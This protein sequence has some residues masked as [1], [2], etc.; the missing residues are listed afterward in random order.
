MQKKKLSDLRDNK[1]AAGRVDIIVS[2]LNQAFDEMRGVNR[3]PNNFAER[4]EIVFQKAV[5]YIPLPWWQGEEGVDLLGRGLETRQRTQINSYTIIGEKSGDTATF[6]V[7]S[8]GIAAVHSNEL[9][10]VQ[11]AQLEL[12]TESNEARLHRVTHAD[13][14]LILNTPSA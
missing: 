8:D 7:S 10:A 12:V 1:S 4:G 3:L 2:A 13:A 9:P 5:Q 6:F 14:D 11:E